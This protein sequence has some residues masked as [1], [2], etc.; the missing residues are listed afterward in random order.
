M[1]RAAAPPPNLDV[2]ARKH[3]ISVVA[4]AVPANVLTFYI[5]PFLGT[6]PALAMCWAVSVV[7]HFSHLLSFS[8]IS[9]AECPAI[10]NP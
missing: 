10:L 3:A 8:T 1:V 5:A 7:S 6:I 2:T 9:M 4:T